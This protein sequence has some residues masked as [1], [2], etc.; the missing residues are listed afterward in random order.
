MRELGCESRVVRW[1]A[2][3]LNIS[4]GLSAG[5]RFIVLLGLSAKVAKSAYCLRYVCPSASINPTRNGPICVQFG[6]KDFY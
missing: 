5:T 4:F 1:V 6:I 3:R 2:V